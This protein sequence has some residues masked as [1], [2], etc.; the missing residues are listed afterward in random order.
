MSKAPKL[1]QEIELSGYV[2]D[3]L[4]E[5]AKAL[6]NGYQI[7]RGPFSPCQTPTGLLMVKMGLPD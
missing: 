6:Q 5:Y 7:I 1:P 4:T 2:D 3:F